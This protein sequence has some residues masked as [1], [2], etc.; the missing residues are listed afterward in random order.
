MNGMGRLLCR[1][2]GVEIDMYLCAES[3]YIDSST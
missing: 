1:V 2:F 3:M